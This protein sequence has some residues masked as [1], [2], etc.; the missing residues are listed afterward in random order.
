MQ[1][2]VSLHFTKANIIV[3][4][5]VLGLRFTFSCIFG[6]HSKCSSF[7]NHTITQTRAVSSDHSTVYSIHIELQRASY[8][9][10]Q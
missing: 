7:V 8:N 9:M 10:L 1:V 3:G 5:K 2:G 4:Y 6:D